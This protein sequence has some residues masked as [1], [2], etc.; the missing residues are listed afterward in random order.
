M[1]FIF[2]VL[3]FDEGSAK[4]KRLKIIRLR[5]RLKGLKQDQRDQRDQNENKIRIKANQSK[6]LKR[7]R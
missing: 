3:F 4:P 7:M 6:S 2:V 1:I 5:L